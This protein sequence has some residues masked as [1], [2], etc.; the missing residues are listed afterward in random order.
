[1]NENIKHWL[2]T[3]VVCQSDEEEA[4]DHNEIFS[5]QNLYIFVT[6]HA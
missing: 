4:R 3:V 5:I 6:F 2:D 1:M